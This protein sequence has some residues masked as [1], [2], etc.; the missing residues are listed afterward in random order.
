MVTIALIAV[1]VLALLVFVLF[2]ALLEMYRDVRQLRD[3]VG[4]LDRPLNVEVGAVAG[5]KPSK[6]GLPHSLDS[7]TSAIVLFLS[8]R[9]A[10]CRSLV[11]GLTK[12]LPLGLWVVLEAKDTAAA[13]A[14][15]GTSA[16]AGAN[17]EERVIVDVAG[18]IAGRMGLNATPVGLRVEK[19][20][21][22]SATTV[23]SSR[24]LTS[25][26]PAPIR[27]GTVRP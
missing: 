3:V 16:L 27:L 26:L 13:A 4:I 9:C 11:A 1:G 18:S 14:F 15:L 7:S 8:E 24:Y 22:T 10:T 5:T 19:G 12:P 6:Y 21:L 20:I 17:S 2:G 25:I 23:P